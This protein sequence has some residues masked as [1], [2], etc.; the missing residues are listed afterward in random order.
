[1]RIVLT[2]AGGGLGRAFWSACPGHHDL[3]AFTHQELDVGDHHAVMR[4]VVPLRPDLIVNAAAFT[5]VD[6]C[7]SEPERAYRDNAIGPHNLALAAR[8]CGAVLIHV[9]TDFVF[10]GR[11]GSPYDELDVP[12]PL[13]VYARSKLGGET[14]VRTV[15]PEHV[16]VRTG[17]VFGGGEDWVSSQVRAM[18][19][20]E[21]G[22]GLVDRRGTPTYV[23]HLAERLLPLALSGR[24]GTYHLGGPEPLSYFELLGRA[25]AVGDLPGAVREQRVEELGLP[26]PRPV[27]SSLA[28][29]F[30]AEVGVPAMPPLEDALR[31]LVASI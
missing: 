7:E 4:T 11:K 16:V 6:G 8:A 5:K 12:N 2:G 19:T 31:E 20:G 10:D 13:S 22:A 23:R 28:S 14:A 9:S 25:R 27:D 17:Y 24:F 30:V 15:T 29:L 1:M 18:A 3:E 21:P 26:A